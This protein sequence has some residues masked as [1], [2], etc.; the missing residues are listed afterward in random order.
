MSTPTPQKVFE[1]PPR[2]AQVISLFV[3]CSN[4]FCG[5]GVLILIMLRA[6]VAS[7][8]KA[9]V[10]ITLLAG[11]VA[12]GLRLQHSGGVH[13]GFGVHPEGGVPVPAEFSKIMANP[14]FQRQAE[15]VAER[16]EALINDPSFQLKVRDMIAQLGAM[17][18]DPTLK[19]QADRVVE[20]ME[21]MAAEMAN[22][23]VQSQAKRVAER[24]EAM[25]SDPSFQLRAAQMEAMVADPNLKT[26][27]VAAQVEAMVADPDL[28]KQAD[29]V[30]EQ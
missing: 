25:I 7:S 18:A 4:T 19:K 15:R 9:A 10:L 28:K 23:N 1:Q 16:M 3:G 29:H 27:D 26:Q 12:E 5:V 24:M 13:T 30:V 21:E 22:P 17:V 11:V 8:A 20:E 14:D 2:L 6:R